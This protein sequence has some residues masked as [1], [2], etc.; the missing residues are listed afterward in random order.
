MRLREFCRLSDLFISCIKFAIRN[1]F[2]DSAVKEERLLRHDADSFAQ[3]FLS[4]VV[5]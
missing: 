1:I 5:Q 4:H 2:A 3:T